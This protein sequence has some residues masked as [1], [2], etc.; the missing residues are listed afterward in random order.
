MVIP[1]S[2]AF[3]AEL[4]RESG[5]KPVYLVHM[6]FAAV[7]RFALWPYDVTFSGET[8]FGLGPIQA[9]EPAE[10]TDTPLTEQY[11]AFFVQNDPSFLQSLQ[12]SSR[13]RNC[14]I[15]LVFVDDNN[16]AIGS[17]SL[18]LV[19]RRMVPGRLTG[20]RGEYVSQIGLESRFH[21]HRLRAPRTY[22]HAEQQKSRDNT[23]D[24]FMDIGKVLDLTRAG[25]VRKSGL[26]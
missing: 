4:E 19:Y 11:L 9:M 20:G 10:W 13:G 12:Q 15:R 2:A 14:S 16:V 26:G 23:D 17:D 1:V 18:F 3:E 5:A 25:Y 22:S 21:R 8:F 24:A 7:R 6:A